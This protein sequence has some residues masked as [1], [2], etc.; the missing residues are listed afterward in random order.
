MTAEPAAKRAR[1]LLRAERVGLLSTLSQ[2]FPGY[3]FGSVVS[4][5]TDRDACPVF[6]IS[7]LAEHT[8]NIEL[9]PRV[10]FL[11]HEQHPDDAQAAERLTL[12]GEASRIEATTALKARYLR[13]YPGARPYFEL[14]FHFYR[15]TPRHLRYIG[16]PGLARWLSPADFRPPANDLAEEEEEALA[17]INR[18][19]KDHLHSCCRLY[20]GKDADDAE[21]VGIDCDGF[22]I[23]ADGELLRFD[24]PGPVPDTRQAR[25]TLIAMSRDDAR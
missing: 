19:D 10:S 15:V 11:V 6:L 9:D 23:R 14:D 17:R 22:D 24:F 16:G 7:L 20:Y 13:Y 4:Y 3:P 5:V 12:V 21:M 1:R 18:D 2:K 8:R 25:A